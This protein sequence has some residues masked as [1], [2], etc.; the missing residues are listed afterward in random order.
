MLLKGV[1]VIAILVAG[2]LLFAATKPGSFRIQR[3]M[4]IQAPPEKVFALINDFH[5]WKLWAPQEPA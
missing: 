2:V 4:S 5:N 3:S 1:I